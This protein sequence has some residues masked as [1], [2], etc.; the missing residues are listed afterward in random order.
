MRASPDFLC[1]PCPDLSANARK[2]PGGF[3]FVSLAHIIRMML[4]FIPEVEKLL[5]FSYNLASGWEAVQPGPKCP[6]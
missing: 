4:G 5:L 6:P 2:T 3:S 1:S